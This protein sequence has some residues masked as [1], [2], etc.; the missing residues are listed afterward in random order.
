MKNLREEFN[1][2]KLWIR[3]TLILGGMIAGIIIG[4]AI[5]RLI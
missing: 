1:K 4:L 3:L 2:I 5:S